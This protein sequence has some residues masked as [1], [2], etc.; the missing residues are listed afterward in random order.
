[1]SDIRREVA[2]ALPVIGTS[3]DL[4]AAAGALRRAASKQFSELASKME[5]HGNL[6]TAGTFERLAAEEQR[7][8]RP[9]E[10]QGSQETESPAPP[11]LERWAR[12]IL[13]EGR[14]VDDAHLATPYAAL[15]VAVRD[16]ERIHD[17]FIYLAALTEAPELK[18]AAERL[19][20]E[21]F[22]RGMQLRVERRRAYRE[23]GRTDVAGAWP[24]PTAVR[25]LADL[26]AAARKVERATA[27]RHSPLAREYTALSRFVEDTL[28]IASRL[29][30]EA[31]E[32]GQ[33]GAAMTESLQNIGKSESIARPADRVEALRRALGDAERAFEFY[34][35]VV[36]S[37]RDEA[38]MERAQDLT[39][40]ALRR[41]KFLYGELSPNFSEL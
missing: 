27:A 26:I 23:P 41:V 9:P 16:I 2:A 39:G 4:I 25:S 17:A 32:A 35:V 31:R 10:G 38:V 36:S 30:E 14:G 29:D 19:A 3:G 20:E 28:A 37:A 11:E 24:S 12:T 21:E 5:R 7:R 13:G 15:A 22:V 8:S 40:E 33:P 34:D 1:M 18:R 6:A